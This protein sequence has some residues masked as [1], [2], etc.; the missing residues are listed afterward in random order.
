MGREKDRLIAEED[1]WEE[2]ARAKAAEGAQ[3]YVC[4]R[5]GNVIPK[6]EFDAGETQ[7][8]WCRHITTK[9]D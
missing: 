1:A 2:I 3:G 6:S 5:C 4:S 7:C 9:D 8:G